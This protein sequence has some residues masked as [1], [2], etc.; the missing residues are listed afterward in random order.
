EHFIGEALAGRR[1]D[2]FLATKFGMGEG[3]NG[4]PQYVRTALE[5]SLGSLRTDFVDLLYYHR[6]DGATPIAESLGA[7]HGPVAA[8]RVRHLG[9]ADARRV[10][11]DPRLE[12]HEAVGQPPCVFHG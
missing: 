7:M 10:S 5:A 12:P 4:S 6:P 1:D 9:A 11:R 8:G 3:G 2:A